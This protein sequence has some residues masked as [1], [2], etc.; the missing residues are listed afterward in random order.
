MA[1]DDRKCK[2][3]EPASKHEEKKS[4]ASVWR[5]KC[6]VEG[7]TCKRYKWAKVSAGTTTTATPVAA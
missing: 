3:G 2:C 6:V 5:G 1:K 7:S 4:N